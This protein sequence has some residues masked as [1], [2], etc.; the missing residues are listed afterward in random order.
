MRFSSVEESVKAT[1]AFFALFDKKLTFEELHRFLY[2]AP[3]ACSM[4]DLESTLLRMDNVEYIQGYYS[5]RGASYTQDS[6]EQQKMQDL[7]WKRVYRYVPLLRMLPFV[8][9]VAVGNTHAFG[10]ADEDSDIDLF[11]IAAKNHVWLVRFLAGIFLHL[12]GVRRHGNKIEKRFCLSFYIDET[13]CTF[14]PIRIEEDIYMDF[15]IATL[16]PI[17]GKDMYKRFTT[18]NISISQDFLHWKPL[19]RNIFSHASSMQRIGEW[20]FTTSFGRWAEQK[21]MQLQKGKM[22]YLPVTLHDTSSVVVTDHMLKFHNNDRR[23]LYRDT[24]KTLYSSL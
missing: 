14:D 23:A 7:L 18:A 8:R 19:E 6:M 4:Q 13:V 5:L 17:L 11:I 3:V 15:W 1:L 21:I 12:L 10:A 24:W 20:F 22:H 2:G 16:V 9:M